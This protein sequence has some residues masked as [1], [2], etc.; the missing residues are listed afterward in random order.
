MYL[1][2]WMIA[3]L[4]LSFGFCAYISRNQGFVRGAT[5]TL[6]ALEEQRLIKVEDDGQI[7]R[8]TPYSELPKKRTRKKKIDI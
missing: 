8:W 1:D 5:V 3:T 6:Q 2:Y 4:I 7:K